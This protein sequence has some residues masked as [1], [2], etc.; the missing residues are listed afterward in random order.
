MKRKKLSGKRSI[1]AALYINN[2]IPLLFIVLVF[3]VSYYFYTSRL[4]MVR[5]KD[6]L[7]V[8]AEQLTGKLDLELSKMNNLALNISY[9][10]KI[11]NKLRNYLDLSDKPESE[12]K[13][14]NTYLYASSI[15]RTIEEITGPFK[16]VPQINL[17]LPDKNLLGA[18]IYD[19]INPLTSVAEQRLSQYN[20]QSGAIFYTGLH[21][22]SLAEEIIPANKNQWFVSL[23]KTVYDDYH[24]GLSVVEVKQFSDTLFKGFNRDNENIL[25]FNRKGVQ[26]YPFTNP[27]GSL[28]S[29]LVNRENRNSILDFKNPSNGKREIIAVTECIE[30][31]WIVLTISNAQITLKPVYQFLTV[32]SIISL[33]ILAAGFLISTILSRK[34]TDPLQDLNKKISRLDWNLLDSNDIFPL[35]ALTLNEVHELHLSFQEMN[36]KLDASL[37]SLVAEKTLQTQSRILALQAQMDP[38]FIYNMMT[39]ISIMAEDGENSEIIQTI[40]QLSQILRYITDGS[41]LCV[42]LKEELSIVENY[43]SCMKIRYGNILK[44]QVDLPKEMLSLKV[45]RHSILPIIENTIKYGLDINPPWNIILTGKMNKKKWEITLEDNGPGFTSEALDLLND[46]ISQCIQDRSKQL[47]FHINGMGLIN[48][49]SRLKIFYGNELIFSAGNKKTESGSTITIGGMNE[50]KREVFLLDC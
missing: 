10:S 29:R 28:Y 39:N 35:K 14:L 26:I 18:G 37:S 20:W 36:Q 44:F 8:L 49:F 42:L 17:I 13:R 9:S 30:S 50:P 12:G 32:S 45:P 3:T 34:I 31:G 19:L 41:S 38:H 7:M 6:S 4:L 23:F 21:R 15:V 47:E 46:Q 2:F 22:D 48:L 25:V 33:L 1:K 11:K 24:N 40:S 43:L 16:A 5:E 27:L